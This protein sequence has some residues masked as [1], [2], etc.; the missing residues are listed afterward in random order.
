MIFLLLIASSCSAPASVAPCTTEPSASPMVPSG[1]V[2]EPVAIAKPPTDPEVEQPSPPPSVEAPLS[3][4]HSPTP[5]PS[6]PHHQSPPVQ[7][8]ESHADLL[9]PIIM[10]SGEA[11]PEHHQDPVRVTPA[12]EPA[13]DE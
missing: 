8:S 12:P 1:R 11:S 3:S 10:S 9:S 13:S 6:P 2:E 5:T 4:W 7:P